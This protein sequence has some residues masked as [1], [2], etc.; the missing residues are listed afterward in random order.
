MDIEI[1]DLRTA[2]DMKRLPRAIY[3]VDAYVNGRW[4][5]VM[6]TYD[7]A[8]AE[9]VAAEIGKARIEITGRPARAA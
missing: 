3:H 9:A 7:L 6:A 8:K 1:R 4:T 5:D 2:S